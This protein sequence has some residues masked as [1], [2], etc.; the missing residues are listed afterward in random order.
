M[1]GTSIALS[2][3]GAPAHEAALSRPKGEGP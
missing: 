2:F 1:D 3:L